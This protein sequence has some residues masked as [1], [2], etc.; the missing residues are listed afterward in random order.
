MSDFKLRRLTDIW[1]Q[2]NDWQIWAKLLTKQEFIYWHIHHD[3]SLENGGWAS[4]TKGC[5]T[6]KKEV[7]AFVKAVWM[8]L[9]MGMKC[10]D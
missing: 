7:P 10:E 3:S 1:Y 8:A 9:V 4:N 2:I 6:C 5:L